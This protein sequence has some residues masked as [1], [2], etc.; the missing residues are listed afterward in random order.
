MLPRPRVATTRK[1]GQNRP[2]RSYQMALTSL[3]LGTGVSMALV[4]LA[5]GLFYRD[6]AARRR[7]PASVSNWP[8]TIDCSSNPPAR[9]FTASTSTAIAPS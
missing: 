9:A 8:P 6:A 3:G 5:A 2:H 7:W 1:G 4:V